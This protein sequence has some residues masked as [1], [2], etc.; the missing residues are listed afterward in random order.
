MP[1][2]PTRPLEAQDELTLTLHPAREVQEIRLW[3]MPPRNVRS[4]A[5]P[6]HGPIRRRQHVARETVLRALR[7]PLQPQ[8]VT[9]CRNRR[10][11]LRDL[12]PQH[13]VPSVSRDAAAKI[14]TQI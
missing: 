2:N 5:P 11:L 8:V 3:Q 14:A 6:P 9:T 4:P 7:R 13:P 10:R 12:V 1:I